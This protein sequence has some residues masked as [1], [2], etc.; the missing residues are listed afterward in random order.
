MSNE[1][2]SEPTPSMSVKT[3]KR[4]ATD[5]GVRELRG[6]EK[7]ELPGAIKRARL[8]NRGIDWR[9]DVRDLSVVVETTVTR[10]SDDERLYHLRHMAASHRGCVEYDR[11]MDASMQEFLTQPV[12]RKERAACKK[13]LEEEALQAQADANGGAGPEA[14]KV[15]GR[16]VDRFLRD[17]VPDEN[18]DGSERMEELDE[19]EAVCVLAKG[20]KLIIVNG[21]DEF[22]MQ[23]D[24]DKD[25]EP[26]TIG[27]LIDAIEAV[28]L[29]RQQ[30]RFED[31]EPVDLSH[32]FCE[33]EAMPCPFKGGAITVHWGS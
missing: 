17:A 13:L 5:A 1:T 27:G 32:N 16:R 29:S 4:M 31:G 6:L 19:N 21:E 14:C 7:G 20:A 28:S 9:M 18:D 2:L 8:D 22:I 24:A 10:L 26:V 33:M 12:F 25:S 23:P 30:R 15:A 11:V 3:L